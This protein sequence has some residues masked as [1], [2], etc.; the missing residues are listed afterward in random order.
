M[1]MKRQKQRY[2]YKICY[3]E[4]GAKGYTRHFMTYTY[5]AAVKEL[6]YCKSVPQNSKNDGH[7]LNNPKW[8]IIP[9]S[10]K[11]KKNGIW[12]ECPF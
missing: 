1:Q 9:I 7:L 5:R 6:K 12:Q 10:S 2:G 11:E 8:K 3:K 4:E